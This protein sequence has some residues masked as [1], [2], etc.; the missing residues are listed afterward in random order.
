MT[1][2]VFDGEI[3]HEI[4][5]DDEAR[6]ERLRAVAR[7]L[8]DVVR[9]GLL[10]D[11]EVR[12][13]GFGTFRLQHSAARTGRNPRTG[14]PVEIPARNRVLFRPAKA[15]RER[16]EPHRAASVL[17]PSEASGQAPS[18]G[19]AGARGVGPVPSSSPDASAESH[20]VTDAPYHEGEGAR[21]SR[22]AVLGGGA[23]VRER[24]AGAIPGATAREADATRPRPGLAGSREASLGSDAPRVSRTVATVPAVPP[25]ADRRPVYAQASSTS[26]AGGG[27]SREAALASG[28]GRERGAGVLPGDE[29]EDWVVEGEADMPRHRMARVAAGDDAPN[30]PEP[31][32]GGPEGDRPRRGGFW[33]ALLL[34]LLLL[35]VA[36]WLLWPAPEPGPRLADQSDTPAAQ[37]GAGGDQAAS[38]TA[39]SDSTSTPSDAQGEASAGATDTTQGSGASDT[40]EASASADAGEGSASSGTAAGTGDDDRTAASASTGAGAGGE[41]T[42]AHETAADGDEA[43]GDTPGASANEAAA[44]GGAASGADSEGGAPRASEETTAAGSQTGDA[45]GDTAEPAASERR[46]HGLAAAGAT[47]TP[48]SDAGSGQASGADAG[49]ATMPKSAEAI[50][51]A[52]AKPASDAG[53]GDGGATGEV[54]FEGREYTVQPGDTLWGLADRNYVNPF[55]WPHIWNNNDDL[56]NPDRISVDQLLWLPTLEGEPTNL[57]EAD[58][59]SIA[60]G[61]LQLYRFF[62]ESG[63]ANPGYALVGVRFFD[64]SVLPERLR[65]SAAVKPSTALAATFKARLEA[66]FTPR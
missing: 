32:P 50:E 19:T 1:R 66:R 54:F 39:A 16:I 48:P 49:N 14:E 11:G 51:D 64:P 12:L 23:G 7:N 30:E 52:G 24:P 27:A 17:T 60:E 6:Y 62:K 13:H 20:P 36:L 56:A 5:G 34:V 18:E 42:A 63:D 9:D 57:T 38:Q 55:F 37:T 35:G 45:G 61:Y 28:A 58:R 8:L 21:P 10:R 59:R 26:P 46:R 53:A 2:R 65:G 44:T 41:D 22:E 40:A 29:D 4:A 25:N 3:A 31:V 47:R 33:A 43:G 15:L